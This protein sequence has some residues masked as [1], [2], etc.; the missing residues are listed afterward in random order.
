MSSGPSAPPA[1]PG[2][3]NSPGY[4]TPG[5][6]NQNASQFGTYGAGYAPIGGAPV[7]GANI[8]PYGQGLTPQQIQQGLGKLNNGMQLAQQ[9]YNKMGQ[10]GGMFMN[11]AQNAGNAAYNP[12]IGAYQQALNQNSQNIGAQLASQRG[13]SAD[14]GLAARN[15]GQAGAVAAQNAAG[16]MSS[17]VAQFK[18][19]NQG[20]AANAYQGQGQMAGVYGNIANAYAQAGLANQ[21]QILNAIAAQN[22]ANVAMQSNINSS[23]VAMQSNINNANVAMQSNVNDVMAQQM[24]N[25]NNLGL[26]QYGM[27]LGY[28][29]NIFNSMESVYGQQSSNYQN[30]GLLGLPIPILSDEREKKDIKDAG[31]K[32]DRFLR[33]LGGHEY[34]YKDPKAKGAAKGKF[35]SP[36]AQELEKTELGKSMVVRQP[37]GTKMVDY[38]RGLGTILAA[39]ARLNERLDTIEMQPVQKLAKGGLVKD[40]PKYAYGGRIPE[41]KRR[42]MASGGGVD[43]DTGDDAALGAMGGG[44]NMFQQQPFSLGVDIDLSKG[45]S[46]MPGESGGIPSNSPSNSQGPAS[47]LGKM[48]QG[49]GMQ[50]MGGGGGSG[51]NSTFGSLSKMG[52]AALLAANKGGMIPNMAG[53]GPVAHAPHVQGIRAPMVRAPGI[54]RMAQGGKPKIHPQQPIP[55]PAAALKQ[56]VQMALIGRQVMQQ[57]QGQQMPQQ[58]MRAAQGAIVPDTANPSMQQQPQGQPPMQMGG[59]GA[60]TMSQQPQM[61]GQVQAHGTGMQNFAVAGSPNPQIAMPSTG[62]PMGNAQTVG[63]GP[64]PSPGASG[65]AGMVMGQQPRRPGQPFFQGG[66]VNGRCS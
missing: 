6:P 25:N 46:L 26:Q 23:N 57:G 53:G 38:Q 48:L 52:L 17:Q 36:M 60:G 47:F 54:H 31:T 20:M 49:G 66:R 10:M 3:G 56:L 28:N 14:P 11:N 34:K 43:P 29:A 37:D 19:A 39:Q 22:A 12:A 44:G 32:I 24:M 15:V 62:L 8:T 42:K 33:A 2:A 35:V 27:D 5:R 58:P 21:G 13:S 18:E 65:G 1:P 61:P 40:V 59:Q 7:S 16:Q 50:Q 55:V 64:M 9:S 30:N 45:M 4:I 63:G 41:S 51:G